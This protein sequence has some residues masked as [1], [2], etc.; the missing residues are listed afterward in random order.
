MPSMRGC[1]L[2]RRKGFLVPEGHSHPANRTVLMEATQLLVDF[3]HTE[4]PA[5]IATLL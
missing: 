5:P 4:N 3:S 2:M 1:A